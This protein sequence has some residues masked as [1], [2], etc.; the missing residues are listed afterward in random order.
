MLLNIC[1]VLFHSFSAHPHFFPPQQQYNYRQLALLAVTAL[2]FLRFFLF[3]CTLVLASS[4][5]IWNAR[6]EKLKIHQMK[7]FFGIPP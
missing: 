4:S 2:A 6:H 7:F 5:R 1:T 3:T